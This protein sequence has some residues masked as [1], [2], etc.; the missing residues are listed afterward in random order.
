MHKPRR[1]LL[2]DDDPKDRTLVAETLRGAFALLD[3]AEVTDPAALERAW[4]GAPPDLVLTDYAL[5]W[6]SGLVVLLKAKARWPDVPVV[7]VTGTGSEEIAVECM[8]EGLDD[9]ILKS[10]RHIVRLP[11]AIESALARMR[12]RHALREAE[13]RYHSLFSGIPLGVYRASPTGHVL[14]ANPALARILGFPDRTAC[15]G[16]RLPD[17]Y[18]DPDG[19]RQW[20]AWVEGAAA[21]WE[22]E[23]RMRCRVG[24]VIW[25]EHHGRAA[26]A[27]TG[28]VLYLEGI[29]EDITPRKEA[30]A[31]LRRQHEEL[32]LMAGRL[33]EAEET[34]RRRLA[35]ELHD[36]VGQ[37]LTAIGINVNVIRAQ[38]PA[39]TDSAVDARLED[40]LTLVQETTA[41]IRSVMADLRPPVLDDY[42]LVAALGWYARQIRLRTGLTVE[43]ACEECSP[44][45]AALTETALFRIA[46]EALNNVAKHARASTVRIAFEVEEACARLSIADDGVGFGSPDASPA[47]GD[48]RGWGLRIMK[49]RAEGVGGACRIGSVPREGV[50]IVVEV[51][52]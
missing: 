52:R 20:Q 14:E 11:A 23:L 37:N 47:P 7:M 48:P 30:E 50:R 3:I 49:E 45:L 1:I 18:A 25:V 36:Q 43:V 26:R 38:L 35:R 39:G 29:L 17:L 34:E 46:Q 24:E 21:A 28:Q 44:R 42:G 32:R 51:P 4:E 33:T 12:E 8:K 2:V 41:R 9:Y 40:L 16:L 27:P 31:A 5:G 19:T 6:T 10:P 22:V 13:S 15:V